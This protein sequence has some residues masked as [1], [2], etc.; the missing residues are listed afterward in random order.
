MSLFYTNTAANAFSS[1]SYCTSCTFISFPLFF[2]FL[3]FIGF[4]SDLSFVCYQILM[5]V[6]CSDKLYKHCQHLNVKPNI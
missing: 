3:L 4:V 2:F 5:F 6:K 1:L